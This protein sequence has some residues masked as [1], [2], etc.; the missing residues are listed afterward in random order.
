MLN[1][2]PQPKVKQVMLNGDYRC[3][4]TCRLVHLETYEVQDNLQYVVAFY[5]TFWPKKQELLA[6]IWNEK[7]IYSKIC[8]SSL[9]V[10]IRNVIQADEQWSKHCQ[11]IVK[12]PE[13]NFDL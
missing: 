9:Q 2:L 4:P 7:P 10:I 13:A 8:F 12:L 11:K 3:F 6:A 5:F 1:F